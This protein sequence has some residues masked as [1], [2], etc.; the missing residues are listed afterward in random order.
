MYFQFLIDEYR[1]SVSGSEKITFNSFSDFDKFLN[2]IISKLN[3]ND[4]IEITFSFP[5]IYKS[6]IMLKKYSKIIKEILV[7]HKKEKYYLNSDYTFSD[8][9]YSTPYKT[10]RFYKNRLSFKLDLL[11][12]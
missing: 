8:Y 10:F 6:F 11:I 5:K 7:V 2:E 1:I 9:S 3:T 12:L 4:S